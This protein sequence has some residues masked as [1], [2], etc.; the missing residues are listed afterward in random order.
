MIY[1]Q[2]TGHCAH[3]RPQTGHSARTAALIA[4]FLSAAVLSGCWAHRIVAT[5]NGRTAYV[6]SSH[7]TE[8]AVM[9]RCTA[10]EDGVGCVEVEMKKSPSSLDLP[11]AAP[12]EVAVAGT[13]PATGDRAPDEVSAAPARAS[14]DKPKKKKSAPATKAKV[15]IK[16]LKSPEGQTRALFNVTLPGSPYEVEVTAR[17]PGSKWVTKAMAQVP[18]KAQWTAML[19]LPKSSA[20][21]ARLEYFIRSVEG[22]KER[23]IGTKSSPSSKDDF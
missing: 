20:K 22:G 6:V 19:V 11:A 2:R 5:G 21:P 13:V 17:L 9:L 14:A 16:R 1:L 4:L 15:T 12:L 18:G 8:G 7:M 3:L 10:D 23:F